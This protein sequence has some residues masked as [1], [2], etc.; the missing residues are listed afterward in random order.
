MRQKADR[1]SSFPLK[2]EVDKWLNSAAFHLNNDIDNDNNEQGIYHNIGA[3]NTRY[4]AFLPPIGNKMRDIPQ[5]H[6]R[7]HVLIAVDE[8]QKKLGMK[9]VNNAVQH[10][11]ACIKRGVTEE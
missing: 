5:Q 9:L 2:L 6:Q 3:F 8:L 7:K 11:N 1:S 10:H 4:D